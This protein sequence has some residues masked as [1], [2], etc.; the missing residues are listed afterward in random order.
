MSS[1]RILVFLTLFI[2]IGGQS[3]DDVKHLITQLF[4]TNDYVKQ[5]RPN[6]NQL[7]PMVLDLDFFLVGIDEVDELKQRLITTGYLIIGWTDEYLNWTGADF[8][9]LYHLYVPQTDIWMPDITLKN[10]FTK[11]EKLGSSFIKAKV[12]S[13]GQVTWMPFE[14]FESKCTIDITY[15]P[16]DQQSCNIIFVVWSSSV[17][18]V[19]VTLWNNGI[20]LDSME[21]NAEWSVVSTS[22]RENVQSSEST[23]I[24]TLNLKRS[25]NYYLMNIIIPIILLSILNLFTFALPA[26][27]GEK[28]GYCITVFLSFAVF[29]TIVSS[30][31]PKTSGSI[32]GYYLMFQLGMGTFVVCCTTIELRLHHRKGDVPVTIIRIMKCRN[33]NKITKMEH[34]NDTESEQGMTWSDVVSSLDVVLFWVSTA[35]VIVATIAFLG[36]LW[37]R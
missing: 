14:V 37:T 11:L 12:E 28:M 7:Q 31:L 13:N 6:R 22:A 9:G 35:L 19:M 25:S 17:A 3:G 16:Y 27:S 33:V 24:F 5:V 23:V 29:L 4:T 30:E 32:L 8:G 18:D 20:K 10:G 36:L 2:K 26:D 1:L 34:Q 21:D 15:F